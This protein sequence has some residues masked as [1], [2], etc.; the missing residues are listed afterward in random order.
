[1]PRGPRQ[2]GQKLKEPSAKEALV[3]EVKKVV[4]PLAFK[5]DKLQYTYLAEE[6]VQY[7]KTVSVE[8]HCIL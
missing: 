2:A 7:G 6:N 4:T 1:M 8:A 5:F 3:C